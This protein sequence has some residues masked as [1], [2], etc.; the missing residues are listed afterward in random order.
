MAQP[1]S[2]FAAADQVL[3]GVANSLQQLQQ[4]TQLIQQTQQQMQ[5][6][7]QQATQQMQQ[8]TQ[9]MQ[10]VNQQQTQQIQQGQQQ[11]TQQMQQALQQMQQA[12]QQMQQMQ[13]QQPAPQS[14]LEGVPRTAG[15]NNGLVPVGA[16][17]TA[18]ELSQLSTV[19]AGALLRA[20]GLARNGNVDVR[21]KRLATHLGVRFAEA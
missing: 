9:Q 11:Q 18:I 16:P 19:A 7:M 8:A 13:Q 5:Q 3:D 14:Q 20:Y 6:Q 12:L 21:R 15:P 2:A 10:Q 17:Q 1:V 4:Q